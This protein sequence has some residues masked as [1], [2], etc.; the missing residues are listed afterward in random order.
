MAQHY[1]EKDARRLAE[2]LAT[3]TS[4][5]V[6]VRTA[7]IRILSD[8][9]IVT[10]TQEVVTL[11]RLSADEDQTIAAA[12]HQALQQR[13]NADSILAHYGVG[14]SARAAER[15]VARLVAMNEQRN[16]QLNDMLAGGSGRKKPEEKDP[17]TAM[18]RRLRTGATDERLMA[19]YDIGQLGDP[20]GVPVVVPALADPEPQARRVALRS[21]R[22]LAEKRRP[23]ANDITPLFEEKDFLI[24]VTA[25]KAF[26]QLGI[27]Q[28]D[29]F[30]VQK[31]SHEHQPVVRIALLES[32][33]PGWPKSYRRGAGCGQNPRRTKGR[34]NGRFS[35]FGR[36]QITT[37][38]DQRSGSGGLGRH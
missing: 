19:A 33:V 30:L 3:D 8:Q 1:D 2:R 17:L 18:A 26:A 4:R 38:R 37:R 36:Q 6:P 32:G 24:R 22:H 13:R 23:Q 35:C 25:A 34:T 5:P 10:R 7:A 27:Q 11:M 20:D 12:A 21:L 9:L 14:A 16:Q 28:T 29:G 15:G 31:L